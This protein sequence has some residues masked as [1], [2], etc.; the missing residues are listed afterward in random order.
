MIAQ[1]FGASH[2]HLVQQLRFLAYMTTRPQRM[3]FAAEAMSFVYECVEVTRSGKAKHHE[4][5]VEL[6]NT[7]R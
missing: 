7:V 4:Q 6:Q 2:V 5:A 1:C 3:H